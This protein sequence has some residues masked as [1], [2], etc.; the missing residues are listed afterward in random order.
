LGRLPARE[1]PTNEPALGLTR[2]TKYHRRLANV[3]RCVTLA[4]TVTP[5]P[6]PKAPT[7]DGEREAGAP[8]RKERVI[9]TRV[10]AVLEQELK[11]LAQ[12]LR[13]PVSNVVR[14]ILED[15]VDAVDRVGRKAEG[16]VRG[17]AERLAHNRDRLRGMALGHGAEGTSSA[18]DLARKRRRRGDDEPR[19][20]HGGAGTRKALGLEGIIGF[21]PLVL[22]MAAPCAGCGRELEAGEEAFL[23]VRN[24]DGPRVLLGQ[25]CLPQTK[26]QGDKERPS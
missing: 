18:D 10:P 3:S 20:A 13:V 6:D 23:G 21:Q 25:E 22:A 12:A 7:D 1:D 19:G 9:H 15:A 5:D 17:L 16:E 26:R 11:R 14:V 8:E 2:V 4:L 24:G